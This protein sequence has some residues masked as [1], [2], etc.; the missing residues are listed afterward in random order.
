MTSINSLQTFPLSA[1]INEKFYHDRTVYVGDAAHS[2]HPIAGQGWN[3]ALRDIKS[4]TNILK[5]S[6][7]K[8]TEIGTA[9]FCKNYNDLCFY[10]AYRLFEITDKFD[11]I[12]KKDQ[13][14]FILLKKLGFNLINQ[15]KTLKDKIVQFAMGV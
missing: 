5:K 3:L 13:S 15:N 12:F 1:H 11:W 8:E 10:D 4:L 2:I 14:H 9:K 7:D 6:K